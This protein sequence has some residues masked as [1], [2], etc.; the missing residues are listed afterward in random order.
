MLSHEIFGA[1]T[2]ALATEVLDFIHQSEKP[3]YRATLEAVATHRKLRPVFLER[4]SRA[5]RAPMILGSL[6]RPELSLIADNLLRSWLLGKHASMLAAFLTNL[7]IPNKEGAVD[8]LPESVG[9]A[10]LRSSIN[11]LLAQYPTEAVAVYLNAFNQ[12]NGAAW[13]NLDELLKT[14]PRL[15]LPTPATA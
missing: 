3:L 9:E 12:F 1:L 7:G 8:E 2:P 13:A 4:M 10:P 5:E 15:G 6:K 14:D 11:T